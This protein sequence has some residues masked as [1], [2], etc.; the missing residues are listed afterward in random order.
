MGKLM[1]PI[2]FKMLENKIYFY[3]FFFTSTDHHSLNSKKSVT[4][5]LL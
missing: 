1:T 5:P 3:A 4:L 2:L